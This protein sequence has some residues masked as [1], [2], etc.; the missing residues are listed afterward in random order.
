MDKITELKQGIREVHRQEVISD[1]L[2]VKSQIMAI[3]ELTYHADET[4]V[5]I[6]D[7]YDLASIA[8]EKMQAIEDEL[9][10]TLSDIVPP[11][12]TP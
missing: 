6:S 11:S 9:K 8:Y 7:I 10:Q 5:E 2:K 12:T 1:F 4:G 3:S